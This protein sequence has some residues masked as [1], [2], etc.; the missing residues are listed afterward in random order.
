M[1]ATVCEIGGGIKKHT[2]VSDIC[3]AQL[4]LV[5]HKHCRG[6]NHPLSVEAVE[7][8]GSASLVMSV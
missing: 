6:S 1:G 3:S 2:L 8:T 5:L 4:A 7:K